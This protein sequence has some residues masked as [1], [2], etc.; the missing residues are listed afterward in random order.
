MRKAFYVLEQSLDGRWLPA[1]YFDELPDPGK[2]DPPRRLM[3]KLTTDSPYFVGEEPQ[4]N[5]LRQAFP[6]SADETNS[7]DR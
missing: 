5:L 2:S 1:V 4:W 6:E 3:A 7:P